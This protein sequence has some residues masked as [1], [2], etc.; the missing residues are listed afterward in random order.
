MTNY[1]ETETN[2]YNCFRSTQLSILISGFTFWFYFLV[3]SACHAYY[4]TDS[5]ISKMEK[6]YSTQFLRLLSAQSMCQRCVQFIIF[7]ADVTEGPCSDEGPASPVTVAASQE[8]DDEERD[9]ERQGEKRE[10]TTKRRD[11]EETR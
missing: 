8:R 3:L 11:D 10:E 2:L 9:E 7:V 1:Y 4:N 6:I 5:A